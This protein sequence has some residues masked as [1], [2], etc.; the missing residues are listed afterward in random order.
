[1][2]VPRRVFG[3]AVYGRTRLKTWRTMFTGA[4]L[5]G[6][7]SIACA[8][9]I[10]GHVVSTGTAVHSSNGC[11]GLDAVIGEPVAGISSNATYTISAGYF[12][13]LP[14]TDNIFA[15]GFEDCTP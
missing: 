13:T 2:G 15:N 7:L 12:S 4:F 9:E 10:D 11:Y 1:M 14:A 3:D 8:Y 6:A 5:L